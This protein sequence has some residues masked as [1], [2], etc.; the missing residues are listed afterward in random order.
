MLKDMV[1]KIKYE[2]DSEKS[3]RENNHHTLLLLLEETCN[4]FNS[5]SNQRQLM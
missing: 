1:T 3:E 5:S 2:I 4:K